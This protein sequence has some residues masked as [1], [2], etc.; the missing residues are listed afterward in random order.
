MCGVTGIGLTKRYNLVGF[1][2]L[3]RQAGGTFAMALCYLPAVN[4]RE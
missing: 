2:A 1:F 3:Y 4:L